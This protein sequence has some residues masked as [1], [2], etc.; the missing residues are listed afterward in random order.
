MLTILLSVLLITKSFEANPSITDVIYI[1]PGN[2]FF[3][4]EQ[5]KVTIKQGNP[6]TDEQE[7]IIVLSKKQWLILS[8]KI[9][10]PSLFTQRTQQ[11]LFANKQ[12]NFSDHHPIV[13]QSG[14]VQPRP[15]ANRGRHA[16]CEI[17]W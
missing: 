10:C 17:C 8:D 1:T 13:S 5:A 11:I 2:K 6:L 7:P 3:S 12:F 15:Q 4:Y 9:V 14:F 16:Y